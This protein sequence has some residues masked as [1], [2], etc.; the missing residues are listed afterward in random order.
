MRQTLYQK[1]KNCKIQEWTIWIE[2]GENGAPPEIWIEH[3]I[4]GGKKQTT[5]SIIK[6]GV[7][8]GKANETTPIE[9]A[10]LEM[11]RKITKQK[12]DG[13]KES[14]EEAE[15]KQSIDFSSPFPKELCFYKPKSKIED[16]KLAAL[17]KSNK[18]IKTLKRDGQMFVARTTDSGKI[19]IWS[20]KMDL[21]TDKFPHIVKALKGLP[22]KTI[23]LGEMVFI[24]ADG[25][26]NFKL[27]SG[28]CR[29]DPEEAIRKQKE[30]GLIKYY[31]F[32]IAFSN[33]INVL[34]T[35]K[36]S[37]RRAILE[38]LYKDIDKEHVLLCNILDADVETCMHYIEENDLEGL[39]IWDDSK[40]VKEEDAFCFNG[41]AR[42]PSCAF[43]RKNFK[44]DDFII[45][46]DPKTKTGDYG[47]GK[48]KNWLGKV[49]IYQ[50][51]EGQEIFL[52]KCGGGLSD[53]LREF[54]TD[55]SLFPRVWTIKYEFA[56]PGTGKLRFPVFMRD[57]T[58]AKDKEMSECIMSEEII[59][60]RE[61]EVEDEEE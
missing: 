51:H 41:S 55:V 49:F 7:N 9:Q 21:S 30:S 28:I 35:K 31:I 24:N 43:K 15:E 2:R 22:K 56:Q 32:D 53:E 40:L 45:R 5:F 26:D 36:F 52:G 57:R 44:E 46:W 14:I 18:A 61:E 27:V 33:G 16:D 23:L 58:T 10:Q 39:V 17:E 50:I 13:Y 48:L 3:G 11:E 25:T 60:A 29:S 37:E 47:K 20:R 59:A 19:E 4:V 6:E 1:N 8:I 42:R 34:T 54:Y 12:D 38:K